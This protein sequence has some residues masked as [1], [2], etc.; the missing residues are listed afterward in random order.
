MRLYA[1]VVFQKGVVNALKVRHVLGA[2]GLTSYLR[3]VGSVA[4]AAQDSLLKQGVRRGGVEVVERADKTRAAMLAELL[5]ALAYV[6]RRIYIQIH[7]TYSAFYHGV[8]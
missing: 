2:F 8:V 6:Y 4:E 5:D 3:Y 1:M 7:E